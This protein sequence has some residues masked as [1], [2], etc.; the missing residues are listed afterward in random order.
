MVRSPARKVM[1]ILYH[2][3]QQ[4]KDNWRDHTNFGG[5]KVST[6]FLSC[7]IAVQMLV[8]TIESYSS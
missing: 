7:H 6:F 3:G 2:Q 8:T 1:G 4:S 5:L